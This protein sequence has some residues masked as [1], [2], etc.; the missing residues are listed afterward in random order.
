MLAVQGEQHG[1]AW[2]VEAA[3]VQKPRKEHLGFVFLA[4]AEKRADPDARVAGP[5]EAVV[6]VSNA[7]EHFGQRRGR[8]PT[9]APDGE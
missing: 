7:A 5:R 6:P 9:G 4:G 2:T 3:R 8:G 1:E